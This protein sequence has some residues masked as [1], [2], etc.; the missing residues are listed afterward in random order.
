MAKPRGE[1]RYVAMFCITQFNYNHIYTHIRTYILELG[2]VAVWI[3]SAVSKSFMFPLQ[4]T[5]DNGGK[6]LMFKNHM[7][8]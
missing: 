6:K 7:P 3:Q 4:L 1:N 8:R 2:S 5:Y